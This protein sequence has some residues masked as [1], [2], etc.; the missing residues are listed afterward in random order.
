MPFVLH[1]YG[2]WSRDKV[3]TGARGTSDAE[4]IS[5]KKG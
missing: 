1:G 5:A 3:R 4:A 2:T